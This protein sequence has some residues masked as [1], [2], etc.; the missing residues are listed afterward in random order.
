M[1]YRILFGLS[2]I[3]LSVYLGDWSLLFMAFGVVPSSLTDEYGAL[4]T[5]TA[6]NMEPRLRDN[7]TKGNF[8]V[9]WLDMRGQ[10]REEDGGERVKVPLMH[11]QNTTADIYSGYGLLDTT[12]QDGITA[13]FYDWAQLS[14]SIT[15]S[16]KEERQN[17]G[18]HAAI[19]L[20]NSKIMQAEASLKEL[21]NNCIV[22]GR[23]TASSNLGQFL[24][25]RG[26][27]DTSANG[28]LPIPAIVDANASRSVSIGNING[29][30]HSFWRNQATSSTATTFAGLKQ[31]MNAMYNDCSKGVGGPPDLAVCDQTAWE[32]YFNSLQ[33]Q[34]RYFVTEERTLD[35]LGGA[36][37][38]GLKF[39]KAVLVWDEVVPDV[40]T[41]AEVVD[42][43]GSVT[44]SNITFINSMSLEYIVDRETNFVTT[45]M[46]R[47]ENQD[48]RTGQIL[49]MGAIGTNNRRKN[50]VL[51][52]ISQSITS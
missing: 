27:I 4:L 34:E 36:G 49:W 28:P 39:R 30:T 25:R 18:R 6:R 41:N 26:T 40:E 22:A 46:V 42:G 10:W 33:S 21:L 32:T 19:S 2:A 8:V 31:E 5:T 12:P 51:Y 37:K 3:G 44:T 35:V 45:P 11:A 14:V 29:N 52:G 1:M 16:R 13:A 47:P 38:E 17:S 20:L 23:I 43:V 7:I 24:R 48:A 50:G 15:I 9:A